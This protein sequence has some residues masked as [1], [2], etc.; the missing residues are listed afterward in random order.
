MPGDDLLQIGVLRRGHQH[1]VAPKPLIFS[2]TEPAEAFA[3][4]PRFKSAQLALLLHKALDRIERVFGPADLK[5]VLEAASEGRH[6]MTGP[7]IIEVVE[8]GV[9]V[10]VNF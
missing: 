5:E 7:I 6:V 1:L 10:A 9:S 4:S 3:V 2:V 8:T